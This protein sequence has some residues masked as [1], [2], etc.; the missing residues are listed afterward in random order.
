MGE[1][2]IAEI[3]EDF[4]NNLPL[5]IKLAYLPSLGRVRLRLSTKG[6]DEAALHSAIDSHVKQLQGLIGDI[7]IGYDEE[8]SIEEVVANLLV[9]KKK[10][11]TV[12]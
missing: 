3:I 12:I 7:I 4:E 9:K 10:T 6:S 2:A 1:S 11:F 8:N 5:D